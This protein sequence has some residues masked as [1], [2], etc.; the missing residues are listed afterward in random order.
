MFDTG[1]FFLWEMKVMPQSFLMSRCDDNK[2]FFVTK[3]VMLGEGY[4][5]FGW[6]Y[7]YKR[8]IPLSMISV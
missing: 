5:Q 2:E 3:N 6:L 8:P 1:E 7:F 4:G